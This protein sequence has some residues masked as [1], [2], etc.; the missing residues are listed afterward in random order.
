[1]EP[2]LARSRAH[3]LKANFPSLLGLP[4]EQRKIF[5]FVRQRLQNGFTIGDNQFA[6]LMDFNFDDETELS[7]GIESIVKNPLRSVPIGFTPIYAENQ[8]GTAISIT[9]HK[10]NKRP[11]GGDG[12]V[13]A[14][15]IGITVTFGPDDP[16]AVVGILWGA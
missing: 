4:A 1:M 6:A 13:K 10:L 5:D 12:N 2:T 16:A 11:L 3:P 9:T 8:S 7:S 14:G 15:F